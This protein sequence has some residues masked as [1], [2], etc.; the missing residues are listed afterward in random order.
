MTI[1]GTT[2]GG[3][4]TPPSV[5]EEV[6]YAQAATL[7]SG[8][9]IEPGVFYKI[10]D[11]NIWLEG[12]STTEF[13]TTGIHTRGFSAIGK[14]TL[15]GGAS[16]SIDGITVNGVQIMSGSVAFNT[17]LAT[18][19]ADVAANINLHTSS[20]DYDAI[21]AG[22][23][24]VILGK[25]LDDS[26]NGFVVAATTTTITTSK[27]DMGLGI[28]PNVMFF[29]VDYDFDNDRITRMR[30]DK[31]NEVVCSSAYQAAFGSSTI[32][33]FPWQY[34]LVIDNKS[35]NCVFTAYGMDNNKQVIGNTVSALFGTVEIN[36]HRGDFNKNVIEGLGFGSTL[37][38]NGTGNVYSNNYVSAVT[39]SYTGSVAFQNNEF[40]DAAYHTISGGTTVQ[41]CTF[42]GASFIVASGAAS[43][44]N[45]VLA[46]NGSEI[47]ISNNQVISNSVFQAS[48]L[49][50]SCT[51]ASNS[52][53][54][55]DAVYA[56]ITISDTARC[57]RARVHGT[58]TSVSTLTVSGSSIADGVKLRGGTNITITSGDYT[59]REFD[60]SG[61]EERSDANYSADYTTK[62]ISY[63]RTATG[64]GIITLPAITSAFHTE[65]IVIKDADG[66]AGLNNITVNPTGADTIDGGAS[67]T[68]S[69][70]SGVLR[71]KA[72]DTTKNWET[73]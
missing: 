9:N 14:V 28:D 15:T 44:A 62:Y 73:F 29:D 4:I 67:A 11:K 32:D 66:N 54:D 26:Q 1:F 20:P 68:I 38:F 17:D 55:I 72:N 64:T 31:N 49:T 37:V 18:T 48:I 10:T 70:N 71:L 30:D 39:S 57:A 13:T 3:G 46:L 27:V 21:G 2:S 47:T 50:G 52:S 12:L 40:L 65:E 45:G 25:T 41:G 35:E 42:S 8:G 34:P 58:G 53:N 61:F 36:G 43:R 16:G 7:K 51:N 33:K 59:N 6:T 5:Y 69:T 23:S 19:A 24:I 56:E 22:D 63:Q 60:Q